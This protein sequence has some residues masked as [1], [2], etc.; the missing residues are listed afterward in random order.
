M[1]GRAGQGREKAIG[2][3]G[4]GLVMERRQWSCG[5]VLIPQR[6]RTVEISLSRA[7]KCTNL[8]PYVA[9]A[10][11]YL[12]LMDQ[13]QSNDTVPTRCIQTPQTNRRRPKHRSHPSRNTP[14]R[15]LARTHA[16]SHDIKVQSPLRHVRTPLGPLPYRPLHGKTLPISAYVVW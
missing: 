3:T 9:R 14:T 16:R 11:P 5:V 2:R 7:E 13:I 4:V 8:I 15:T 1:E 12:P 10:R 6:R